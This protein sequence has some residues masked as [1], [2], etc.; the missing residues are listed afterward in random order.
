MGER[1]AIVLVSRDTG[2]SDTYKVIP[3]P[4]EAHRQAEHISRINARVVVVVVGL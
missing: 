1:Y 2:E 4:D 3:D